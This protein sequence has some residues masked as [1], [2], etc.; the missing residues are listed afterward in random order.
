MKVRHVRTGREVRLANPTQYLAKERSQVDEAFAGDVIGVFDPGIFEIGDTLT[1]GSKLEFERIPSFAPEHFARLLSLDPLRRKQL[2]RGIDQ[3]AQEGTIQ[4]YR[5]PHGRAS[6]MILGAVGQ[7][8]MEVTMYRLREEYGVK[9][10]LE[11][12]SFQLARWVAP[13]NGEP[14]DLDLLKQKCSG[15]VVRDVRGRVVVLFEHDWAVGFAEER[16]PD[17]A[18]FETVQGVVV[19]DGQVSS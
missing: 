17:V 2:I 4:L 5:P 1:A 7:L 6:E 13:K 9:A 10:R 12:L 14:L 3:L 15:L 8:Q 19:R 18:F 16:L 11:P